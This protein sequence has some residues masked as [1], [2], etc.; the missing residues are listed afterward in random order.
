MIRYWGDTRHFFLLT[1]S[2]FKSI[3]RG[4]ARAPCSTSPIIAVRVS[5]HLV[6]RLRAQYVSY[7][8]LKNEQP[9]ST[10]FIVYKSHFPSIPE[11]TGTSRRHYVFAYLEMGLCSI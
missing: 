5:H 9:V 8:H 7:G 10:H 2:N 1:L 11:C 6:F 4:G 3:G